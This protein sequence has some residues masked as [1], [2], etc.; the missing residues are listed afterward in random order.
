M[1][2]QPHEFPGNKGPTFPDFQF[3]NDDI[4]LSVDRS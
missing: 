3:H 2:G 4:G 1:K